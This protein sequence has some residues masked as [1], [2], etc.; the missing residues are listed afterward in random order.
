[1]RCY[2]PLVGY[3][4]SDVTR[5]DNYGRLKT[6]VNS[7]PMFATAAPV[8]TE[9]PTG[10]TGPTGPGIELFAASNHGD[11]LLYNGSSWVVADNPVSLGSNSGEFLQGLNAVAIGY[12]S[13][14]TGQGINAVAI[15]NQ[16]GGFTQGT[17]A[18]SIGL[19]AGATGQMAYSVAIGLLSG[20][21]TQGQNSVAIGSNAGEYNQSGASVA[22][23]ID[24]GRYTQ[25]NGSVAIGQYSAT[26]SQGQFAVGIGNQA[27][28]LS[29]GYQAVAIGNYAGATNQASNSIAI[30]VFAGSSTQGFKCIAIGSNAG[31]YSQSNNAIAIGNDAG[32]TNQGSYCIAIGTSSSNS[33]LF[34]CIALGYNSSC[35]QSNTIVLGTSAETVV[36]PGPIALYGSTNPGTALFTVSGGVTSFEPG[37]SQI[38]Y[39][40][41]VYQYSFLQS[42]TYTLT[43]VIPNPPNVI[44]SFTIDNTVIPYG[45][46]L[47][48]L[49]IAGM[50]GVSGGSGSQAIY[51][52]I[53]PTTTWSYIGASLNTV[54]QNWSSGLVFMSTIQAYSTAKTFYVLGGLEFGS[55]QATVQYCTLNLTRI[56]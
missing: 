34:G 36:H 53:L 22:I 47:C 14:R 56:A 46:Y 9:G 43:A 55:F 26:S 3:T 54:Q 41:S 18:I 48:Y 27:G 37:Y 6:C 39:L 1:M 52:N 19:G 17:G 23:G 21:N 15:G 11:Y 51:I 45:T 24:A 44:T 10:P 4:P 40:G 20:A 38:N 28:N 25:G 33:G 16:A 13:G 32:L 35:T 12:Q 31:Q 29:Q 8:P 30:G 7:S 5:P 50:A 49:S 42:T 2:Y